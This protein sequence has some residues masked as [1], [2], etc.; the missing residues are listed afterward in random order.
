MNVEVIHRC[1][2][3]GMLFYFIG[4]RRKNRMVYRTKCVGKKKK[5]WL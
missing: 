3:Y 5:T 1:Y 4:K 2:S